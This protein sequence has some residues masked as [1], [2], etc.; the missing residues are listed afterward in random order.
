M[1]IIMKRKI[2]LSSI[3]PVSIISAIIGSGY[4]IWHFND[5]QVNK[6]Q[7]LTAEVTNLLEMGELKANFKTT[8]ISF[9]Q[10]ITGREKCKTNSLTGTDTALGIYMTSYDENK[11]KVSNPTVTYTDNDTEGYEWTFKVTL[12]LTSEIINYIDTSNIT[13][14]NDGVWGIDTTSTP[15]SIIF[16]NYES[17][18]SWDWSKVTFK[19]TELEP[20]NINGYNTLKDVIDAATECSATYVV[21]KF[22]S[23][24]TT[25]TYTVTFKDYDGTVLDTQTVSKGHTATYSKSNPTR[26][27]ET[28]GDITTE[29]TFRGWDKSLENITSDLTVTA[30]YRAKGYLYYGSYPQSKVS[31]SNIISTLN[32]Q[33]GV[34]TTTDS[35]TSTTTY[36]VDLSKWT[37][38]KYLLKS[39]PTEFMYYTDIESDGNKYRGV[40]F[41]SYR[42]ENTALDAG[43]TPSGEDSSKYRPYQQR[44]KY[45][46]NTVYWFKYET[47]KWQVLNKTTNREYTV[48]TDSVIDSQDY[49][50][51]VV[52]AGATDYQ[53]NTT[54]ENVYPNNYQFSY[55]REWINITFYNNAFSS[56][57]QSHIQTTLVDNSASTT[58]SSSNQWACDNT[59]DKMFLL[60]YK[61][62]N[63]TYFTSNEER[64]ARQ[65]AY[66][67]SQG[68]VADEDSYYW[69]RSPH[70][71]NN[72]T[73]SNVYINGSI[74]GNDVHNTY[75][76]VR[77]ACVI[78][79]GD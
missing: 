12:K 38:Y 35:S 3:L 15:G 73:V 44:N 74:P 36:N 78:K 20:T 76:G 37:A 16:T 70:S 4:S 61:E 39:E 46:T 9:D 63:E 65:T 66:A 59:N 2:L 56:D 31:D 11:N 34:T 24:S 42:P 49:N 41:T 54:T 23:G 29:F 52:K 48:I 19:Y 50:H 6:K 57:E 67:R 79:L 17:A 72:E 21:E 10:S 43:E 55:I 1:Y 8:E 30:Q 69:T 27:N 77:P 26:A 18:T 53:G 71:K 75:V 13:N 64:V 45:Y 28:D 58:I 40:Y 60:S 47:L 68:A 25:K 14:T 5:L 33:A 7:D 62:M 32:S 22:V 51:K